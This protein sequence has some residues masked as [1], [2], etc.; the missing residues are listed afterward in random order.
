M[1][2]KVKCGG[3]DKQGKGVMIRPEHRRNCKKG[4]VTKFHGEGL[5]V[6]GEAGHH[7][8]NHQQVLERKRDSQAAVL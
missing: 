4:E 1:L 7:E 6:E 5:S 8:D 3:E 2:L